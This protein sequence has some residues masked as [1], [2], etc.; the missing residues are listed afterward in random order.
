MGFFQ[1]LLA[2]LGGQAPPVSGDA[3]ATSAARSGGGPSTPR[4]RIHDVIP[5]PEPGSPSTSL[6]GGVAASEHDGASREIP[7]QVRDDRRVAENDDA[8]REPAIG[9]VIVGIG[10]PGAEYE[11]TRHNA[12]FLAIE[13]IAERLGVALPDADP[14]R[15]RLAVGAWNGQS[16]VLAQPQGYMN[17]SGPPTAAL[18]ERHGLSPDRLLLVYDDLSIPPGTIRLRGKGSAGGHNGVQSVIDALG[19]SEFP[20]L[21]IGIGDRFE[22]GGLVDYVLAPFPDSELDALDT[23]L[24]L[25]TEAALAFAADGLAPA[26]N[27]YNRRA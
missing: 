21:R 23:A 18:L 12:G 11:Q 8:R 4:S 9:A 17:R 6:D 24:D 13:R 2:R 3:D 20:R 27:Q 7:D 16:V 1:R 22:R 10:N 26:M 5:A 15:T 25:A 19:S 14:P